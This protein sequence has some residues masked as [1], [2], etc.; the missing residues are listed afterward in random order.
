MPP[1]GGFEPIKYKRNLPV[2]GLSGVALLT[3][4]TAVCTYGF[5]RVGKGNLEKRYV[6]PL[7]PCLHLISFPYVFPF[8]PLFCPNVIFSFPPTSSLLGKISLRFEPLVFK[9]R[10][11]HF[12]YLSF[13]LPRLSRLA[14]QGGDDVLTPTVYS[15][16]LSAGVCMP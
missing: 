1:T 14:P 9:H 4:V 2:R 10:F 6:V 16:H 8:L 7:T 15:V 13:T 12:P 11:S 3:A 5:Y